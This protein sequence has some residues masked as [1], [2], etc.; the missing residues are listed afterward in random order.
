MANIRKKLAEKTKEF[1]GKAKGVLDTMTGKEEKDATSNFTPSEQKLAAIC[2]AINIAKLADL[3][4]ST[5]LNVSN[6]NLDAEQ[7]K[8]LGDFIAGRKKSLH[9][10]S[11]D[12]SRNKLDD[13]VIPV[14]M[15]ILKSQPHLTTLYVAGNIFTDKL[16]DKIQR[17]FEKRGLIVKKTSSASS[18]H[19]EEQKHAPEQEEVRSELKS[20]KS[21]VKPTET[22][23]HLPWA[24][25]ARTDRA[26]QNMLSDENDKG[27]KDEN[28]DSPR[29]RRE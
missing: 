14:V 1:A 6:Q 24:P 28:D 12:I 26:I 21:P 2:P 23:R 19:V 7:F 11:L 16:E 20:T 3:R 18:A 13:S 4:E 10:T 27:D 15:T 25:T 29:F 22:S 9:L 17:T 8:A 5:D